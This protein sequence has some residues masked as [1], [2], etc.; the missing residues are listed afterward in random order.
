[1]RWPESVTYYSLILYLQVQTRCNRLIQDVAAVF[2]GRELEE[3]YGNRIKQKAK[4]KW[5]RSIDKHMYNDCD[6]LMIDF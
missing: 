4:W 1:M 6:V 2:E 3:K 5:L